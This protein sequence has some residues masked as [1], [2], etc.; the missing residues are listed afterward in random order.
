MRHTLTIALALV[1]GLALVAGAGSLGGLLEDRWISCTIT[2]IEGNNVSC[3]NFKFVANDKSA[4]K[5]R[6][7]VYTN[8]AKKQVAADAQGKVILG[9]WK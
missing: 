5:V 7:T 6:Q 3:G 8:A 4:V 1:L 9:S 2:Y